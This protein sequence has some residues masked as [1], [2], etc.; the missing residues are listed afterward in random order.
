MKKLKAESRKRKPIQC[1]TGNAECGTEAREALECRVALPLGADGLPREIMYMPGGVQEISAS[2][3]GKTAV[4]AKLSVTPEAAGVLNAALQ[5]HNTASRQRPYFDFNHEDREASAWPTGFRWSDTPEPG[6]YASVEWST[7][8]RSAI[9]GKSYR[10]FS[11]RFYEDQSTKPWGIEGAPLNMGGLVNKPAFKKILPLWAKA[12]AQDNPAPSEHDERTHMTPEQLAALQARLTQL[13]QENTALKAAAASQDNKAAIEAKDAEIATMRQQLDAANAAVTAQ[14]TKDGKAAIERAI[15]RG[16]IAAKDTKTITALEARCASDPEI[17]G[18]IDAMQGNPALNPEP[19]TAAGVTI[20]RED[21]R[22]LIQAYEA[23]KNPRERG[24]LWAKELRPRL[25]KE[26]RLPLEASNSLGTLTGN[27]IL[28]ESLDLLVEE[29]PMLSVISRNFSD[30]QVKFNQT[31]DTRLITPPGVEDYHATN[32]YAARSSAT[33]TD[34]PITLNVHKFV[35]L[36][37]M[38]TELAGT[39]RDLF[40]EHAEGIQYALGEAL[41]TSLFALITKSNFANETICTLAD[42]SRRAI[43]AMGGAMTKRKVPKLNRQALLSV[44]YYNRLEEDTTIVA[45]MNNSGANGAITTGRL[46]VV[47][48][49]QPHEV[50]SLPTTNNLQGFGL[51]PA[52]LAIASRVPNDYTQVFGSGGAQAMTVTNALTGLSVAWVGYA[53]HDKGSAVGRAALMYGVAKGDAT[54]GQRLVSAAAA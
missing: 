30:A 28:Q 19:I 16:A 35:A 34:V 49:F 29:Y 11:P 1:G 38:T 52:T 39:Q 46:P 48:G 44:D 21:G 23:N 18:V 14:R 4:Q 5:A 6:I 24:A 7:A 51:T 27:L 12:G 3:G 31:I 17:A 10:A 37:F 26:G 9:E 15:K 25:Q 47:R 13:E 45:V 43:I 42:M 22:T 33:A 36:E 2:R 54:T 20:S 32:G 40:A 53:D 41:Y 50:V 8:G